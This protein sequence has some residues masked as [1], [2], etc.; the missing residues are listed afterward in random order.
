MTKRPELLLVNPWVHDFA[1]YDMWAKPMGLLVLASRLRR[2]GWEPR[3]LDCLDVDHPDM[4]ALKR[5]PHAHG[6]FARTAIPKPACLQ[7][8]ARSYSRYGVEPELIRK[9]LSSISAPAA[10]LVTGIMTYWYPGVREVVE[11]LKEYFP[12]TP[13]LLGGIYASLMPDHAREHCAVDEVLTGPGEETLEAAL[14]RHTGISAQTDLDHDPLEFTPALDL[15]NKVRF[16][17]LLTSRGCPFRCAYCASGK[18]AP[19]FVRRRPKD[20]VDEIE[21]A[22]ARYGVRDIAL[23]DDAFLVDAHEH[24]LPILETAAERVPGLT[25]HS[26]NGLHASAIDSGTASVMKSAGFHT[27]RIGL[28]SSSDQFHSTT[29]G[30]TDMAGFLSAVTNLKE[31]GFTSDR[32]GVYLLVGLPGQT[33]ARIEDDVDRVLRA[34]ALPKLAEY[35]PIPGTPMWPAALGATRYPIDKEPLFHNCTLLPAADPDVDWDFLRATRNRIRESIDSALAA[36]ADH[37][38]GLEE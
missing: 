28:E 9:E 29:G 14:F 33:R 8:V 20:V 4:K 26:P 31:V 27:I 36:K 5:K 7:H 30:K 10:I 3:L 22:A 18:L 6:R 17:P 38:D 23:Y 16:L 37:S 1:L 34:G 2:L 32:I 19:A 35:S 15:M 21:A 25:W 24:A 12:G 11:I 13:M